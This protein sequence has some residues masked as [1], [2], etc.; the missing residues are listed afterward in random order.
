LMAEVIGLDVRALI[1]EGWTWGGRRWGEVSRKMF[2][3]C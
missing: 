1:L 3:K 2:Y